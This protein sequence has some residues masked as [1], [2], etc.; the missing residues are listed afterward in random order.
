M[1]QAPSISP[2]DRVP[3]KEK[4]AYGLGNVGAGIQENADKALMTPVF[5]VTVGL[6]P[7]MMSLA[8]L[9]YR[10][11]DA[12]TDLLMG[13]ISDNTRTRWGR[14]RP[15][16][17]LGAILMGLAMPVLFFFNP[18]WPQP[19]IIVWMIGFSM[20][21]YL[22]LTIFN[23]PYQSLLLEISPSSVERTNVAAWRGYLGVVVQFV[24]TWMWWIV[25]LPYFNNARGETD[26]INGARW[27][28]CGLALIVIVLGLLPALFVRERYYANA[29]KQEKLNLWTNLKLTFKNRPFV[30]LTA[31][32]GT[33]VLGLNM[34]WGFDFFVKLYHVCGGD[35]KLASTVAGLQGTLQIFLS[36]AGIPI[37]QFVAR[38]MGKLFALRLT[39]LIVAC[40]SASTLVF[41]QPGYPYLSMLPILLLAPVSSGIWILIPSLNGDVVDFDELHTGERR[42]GAFA[43]V[44][45]WILKFALSLAAAFSGPL[46]ELAGYRAGLH[47]DSIPPEILWNL[48]LF[49]AATPLVF[50]VPAILLCAKFPLTTKRIEE[51]RAE[52]ESRRG[53][54]GAG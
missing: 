45:S 18:A 16:I 35:Q 12:I 49:L 53:T 27:V 38:K 7:S 37:F 5:V 29:S 23:I 40:A 50:L 33:Y 54:I 3:I 10:L 21:L 41:Y 43:S 46:I 22:T 17:F 51:I 44:F 19:G 15:W 42:E 26:M 31:I 20:L 6:S 36:L 4:I 25:Q 48:R 28:T 11:W 32:T 30:I 1:N 2:A 47:R 34:I 8:G 14:R 39:I 13:W 52:L 24:M 9:I